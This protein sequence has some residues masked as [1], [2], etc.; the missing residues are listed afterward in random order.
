MVLY[1]PGTA[2]AQWVRCCATNQKVGVSIPAGVIGIVH[3]H[4]ILP[5]SL[6]PW[7]RLSL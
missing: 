5:I 7:G 2:V 6:W 3:W 1:R 4:K